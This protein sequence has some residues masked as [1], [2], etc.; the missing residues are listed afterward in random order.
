MKEMKTIE[1]RA[2][3]YADEVFEKVLTAPWDEAEGILAEVYMDGARSEL[4]HQWQ[5][6]ETIGE[7]EDDNVIMVWQGFHNGRWRIIAS[8]DS[9]DVW[10]IWKDTVHRGDTLLGWMRFPYHEKLWA[11]WK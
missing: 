7:C 6:P 10:T 5:P 9:P 2:A 8:V 3:A 4:V 1:E 11:A